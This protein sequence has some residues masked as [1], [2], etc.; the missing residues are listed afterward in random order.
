MANVLGELFGDIASAIREKT[1]EEG[2]M[3]PAQFPEKISSIETGAD[4]SGV[5]A[6][7]DDVLAGKIFVDSEG[8]EQYGNISR[9]NTANSTLN[10]GFTK[11]V[12]KAGYYTSDTVVDADPEEVT[13]TPTKETQTVVGSGRVYMH[14]DGFGGSGN[15]LLSSVTVDPIPDKYQDV[16]GVTATADDVRA[17][18]VFVDAEGNE[19]EGTLV[20]E[21]AVQNVVWGSVSDDVTGS[22]AANGVI[23]YVTFMNHDG[24]VEYG[25]KSVLAGENCVD[26]V[27]AGHMDTPT[28]ES[29]AQ[30][31]YTFSG[32]WATEPNGGIDAN[33]LKAVTEDRTVYA[34]F[35]AAVRYYTITFY[36]SDGST[37]LTTKS[38]AYGSVPSYTP[39][40]EGDYS[41]GGWIPELTDVTGAASYTAVWEEKPN[42]T[43]SSWAKIKEICDAG[44]ASEYFA[45]G[46]KRPVTL[47]YSDGTSE[48]I[49]FTIV[50]MNH[51]YSDFYGETKIPLTIMFD[52]IVAITPTALSSSQIG[53]P[54]A[55]DLLQAVLANILSAL[56][57]DLQ[58]V[59]TPAYVYGSYRTLFLPT[60]GNLGLHAYFS[61]YTEMG[62]TS[63]FSYF[64]NGASIKRTKLTDE[65]VDDY[66]VSGYAGSSTRYFV[67]V[68]GEDKCSSTVSYSKS[69]GVVP[70]FCI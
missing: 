27:T 47:N 11:R 23:R 14:S 57:E 25:R 48:T 63:E 70:C 55:G 61:N 13:V 51:H 10:T 31:T 58:A 43:T 8:K 59:I 65:S 62:T 15:A 42:F 35:V 54:Y 26:P 19:V 40:K 52:N 36:D 21:N 9:M 34:N 53:N 2:T 49:N 38:V 41:F 50:D 39:T 44:T 4:V 66:W 30:Y 45:V 5:T 24:T 20:V 46:D 3:K 12:L 28:R 6:T 56:P 32:G 17:G 67:Y 16:S 33:A 18:K 22:L 68:D 64:A 1:G 60:F 7:A 69:H 29:D 37:V